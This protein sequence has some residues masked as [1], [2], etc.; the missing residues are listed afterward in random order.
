MKKNQLFDQTRM[1][2]ALWYSGVMGVILSLL[3][4]GVYQAIAHAHIVTMERE[5]E[6]IA[7]TLHNSLE[8]KLQ[9]SPQ[10][11]PIIQ[12]L[13]PNICL[14]GSPCFTRVKIAQ[15][16]KLA[17]NLPTILPETVSPYLFD[18][19]Q[20]GN[21]YITL[22][23][24]QGCLVAFAGNP[25]K[26]QVF[27]DSPR[28]EY[29]QFSLLLHTT[30]GKDWGYLQVNR[31]F[32]EFEDYLATVRG[33]LFLGLPLALSLV[34]VSSWWL[35]GLA[36]RPIQQSYQQIQQFT[37]DAA[38]ELRTPL[39]AMQATIESVLRMPQLKEEDS[40]DTL[41]TL[42]RQNQRLTTLVQDLLLLSRLTR[43]SVPLEPKSCSLN[44]I[45]NDLVEELAALALAQ[46]I[47]LTAVEEVQYPLHIQGNLEQLYRL[48]SNVLINA[49]QH[50][51]PGGK[52]TVILD[53]D[54]QQ[55][56]IRVQDRGVGI[57]KGEQKR[58]FDRFYRIN[59]D[60]SRQTGG[61]GLGL[62]IAKAIVE[63]HQGK[64]WVESEVGKGSTFIIALPIDYHFKDKTYPTLRTV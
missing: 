56:L 7:Y 64:I 27:Q 19:T 33:V 35:A 30:Q 22:T 42:K 45:V 47:E 55:A 3:G 49:I 15:N 39:A 9:Q 44:D 16:C 58:I 13:L 48:V 57:A 5:L 63:S 62:A 20:Q 50:T 11:E 53:S 8:P 46:G 18:P 32:Q 28:D 21:Y 41:V 6:A 59:S 2:L 60:R 25:P 10:I 36:M 38:H 24:L 34:G 31:S 29:H 43:Q 61:S 51:S 14:R 26:E 23:D 4:W 52:V 37:A 1:K 12:R 17:A 54:P 40:R